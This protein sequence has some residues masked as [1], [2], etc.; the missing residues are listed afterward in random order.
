MDT[1]NTRQAT[2]K[3]HSPMLLSQPTFSL[4]LEMLDILQ[5][6]LSW[7][8]IT[9]WFA[10]MTLVKALSFHMQVIKY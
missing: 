10:I 6:K 5:A 3:H 4:T 1:L 8:L 7:F 9:A 2:P